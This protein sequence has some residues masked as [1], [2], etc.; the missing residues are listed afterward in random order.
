MSKESTEDNDLPWMSTSAKNPGDR[1]MTIALLQ[2]T[3]GVLFVGVWVLVA[4]IIVG[5]RRG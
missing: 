4:H 5:D 2:P 3:M 1:S